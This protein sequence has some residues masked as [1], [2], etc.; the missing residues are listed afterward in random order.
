LAPSSNGGTAITSYQ[1]VS[2]PAGYNSGLLSSSTRSVV[3]TG[4]TN[5]TTYSFTVTVTNSGGLT[6]SVT[7][8]DMIPYTNP[9][10]PQSVNASVTLN[11]T[12]ISWSAPSSDGGRPIT[13][14][15]VI[16]SPAGYNSGSLSSSTRSVVATGLT[17]GTTYSFTVTVTNNGN[18]TNS[19]TVSNVTPYTLP[20]APTDVGAS[21]DANNG[22]ADISW[23]APS[24]NGGRSITMYLIRRPAGGSYSELR[25][26][27][28]S[29]YRWTGL[30][31]N[32]FSDYY[33]SA[34][35]DNINYGP[36]GKTP[37]LCTI[38]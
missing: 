19:A 20:N 1:V 25:T 18:L 32:T 16:S 29:P 10:V 34:T 3:A 37:A 4:L 17:N 24:Y 35:N 23:I 33:V 11:T 5:G 22:I 26:S 8:Y 13:S 14:Y 27:T 7:V 31:L 15:Q 28:T 30:P 21:Q 2:S 12:T 6:S 9:S 36:E 38:M